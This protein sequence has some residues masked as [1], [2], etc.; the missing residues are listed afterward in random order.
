[1]QNVQ[2]RKLDGKVAIITGGSGGIGLA[3]A[4]RFIK[5]G[6][7][8][9]LV[10]LAREALESAARELG[11]HVACSVADVSS[12]EDTQR[13]VHEAVSRFGGVDIVFANAGIEGTVRPL[14]ETLVEDFDRVLRVNVR[15]VW[16]AIKYS[17]PELIKRGGGSI[18]VTSSVAGLIG[19][20]GISPYVT[21]KHAVMG[22]VK[23]AA[24]EL[25][26]LKI[27]INSVNP[28]PIENRM[29]RS[30]ERQANPIDPE[31]VKSGFLSKVALSR[32]GTN[33]EIANVVLFLASDES[34]Y[35]T[36]TS[37]VADGGFVAS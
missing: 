35:C 18:V 7:R 23:C 37:V 10:D 32:Y 21:S 13:Y 19:S 11:E 4:R 16:L 20:P 34:G 28:G 33:E 5:E 29:M 30:I 27:R 14:T 8:V 9:L 17:V 3:T 15:G 25:A 36:G 12:A 22:L 1:V 24:L 6:A 26:P 31:S 2:S